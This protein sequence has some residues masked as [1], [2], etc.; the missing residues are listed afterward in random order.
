MA[1]RTSETIWSVF[2][3]RD[4]DET[5]GRGNGDGSRCGPWGR[6]DDT[7][8]EGGRAAQEGGDVDVMSWTSEMG[9]GAEALR[10]DEVM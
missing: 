3:E 2:L 8:G 7:W 9:P 5:R 10:C 1:M 6:R 4:V